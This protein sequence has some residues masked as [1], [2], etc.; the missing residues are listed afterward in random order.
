MLKFNRVPPTVGRKFNMTSELWEKAE[1]ELAKTF[2]YSPGLV[3][4]IKQFVLEKK[5]AI[6]FILK[7]NQT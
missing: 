1:S 4:I 5:G 2:F 6:N 3:L 7:V